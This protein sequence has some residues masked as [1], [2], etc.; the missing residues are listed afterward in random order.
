[1]S[2]GE[3]A[4]SNMRVLLVRDLLLTLA[5]SHKWMVV[6]LPAPAREAG[7]KRVPVGLHAS[8][9]RLFL[10]AFPHDS[11]KQASLFVVVT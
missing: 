11:E 10:Q 5:V 6:P 7:S 3:L 4:D 2:P 9:Q 8:S 1:M